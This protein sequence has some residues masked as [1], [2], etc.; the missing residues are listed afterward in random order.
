MSAEHPKI[1]YVAIWII[2]SVAFGLSLVATA[3]SD[4]K[5][6]VVFVFVVAIIKAYLVLTKFMHLSVEPR[7][8]KVLVV[9][10]I[11]ALMILFFGLTPDIT[12]QGFRIEIDGVQAAEHG[13]HGQDAHGQ[14]A[15]GEDGH[16]H[17]AQ[18]GHAG[19]G[20]GGQ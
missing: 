3:V 20:E 6:A 17:D 5:A 4:S 1:N 11:V 16:G 12:W 9:S 2:L 14:D 7:V 10:T 18:G 19:A 13:S 8:I 15:H